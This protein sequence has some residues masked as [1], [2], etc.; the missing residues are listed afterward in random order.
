[1]API[2]A[3]DL[4]LYLNVS[5]ATSN[6]NHD[7]LN[8]YYSIFV[9]RNA[10]GYLTF[11]AAPYLFGKL[12][13]LLSGHTC[14]ALFIWNF[15]WW[16]TMCVVLTVLFERF[17]PMRS[18]GLV[19]LGLELTMLFN[20]GALK[21]AVDAWVHLPSL[22]RFQDVGL[23][24]MRAFIPVIPAAL[25]LIYLVLQIE[26]MRRR[27]VSPWM[28]MA[29]LQFVA[30]AVF[31]YATLMMAGISGMSAICDF[32]LGSRPRGWRIPLVYAVA[33]G[34][35]DSVFLLRSSLSFY[36][37]HSSP[38]LLQAHLLPHLI[39]GNWVL[40]SFLTIATALAKTLPREVKWPLLGLGVT[41]LLLLLGDAVVPATTIL[42]SHHAG[43][44]IHTSIAVLTTF[45]LASPMGARGRTAWNLVS[46]GIL[47]A[48]IF[49]N[50]VLVAVA[51]YRAFLPSNVEQA[52][53]SQLLDSEK[54]GPGDLVITRSEVV[55]DDCGWVA[56]LKRAPVLFCT[57]AEVMLTPKQ[58][59]DIQAFRQALYLHLTGRDS[60]Y[61]QEMV[62]GPNP[63]RTMY[64]LGYW[65]EAVSRSKEEREAGIRVIE[66]NL[67]APLQRVES[68]PSA[69]NTFFRQFQRII[70]IESSTHPIFDL[71]RIPSFMKVEGR[72]DL[73]HVTLIVYRPT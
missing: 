46:A 14:A 19:A 21:T 61:L 42:L 27:Q 15:L 71:A 55:D 50:G 44:F 62:E 45:L 4:T 48:F 20:F 12:N 36:G 3:P 28:G 52:E 59:R 9:P 49:I 16:A 23:P 67:V 72:Q 70:V 2:F 58:N 60:A 10:T 25:L 57:D 35:V 17:L 31:P 30:L 54:L 37:S 43:H 47:C 29:V 40:L 68:D 64:Q 11:N 56:L 6:S 66:E 18:S 1:L 5:N 41:N 51:T 8:P 32:F 34:V 7:A 22:T 33:C 73:G 65:T 38:V 63:A 24:Y 26:A 53:L 39:G 13:N 69:V